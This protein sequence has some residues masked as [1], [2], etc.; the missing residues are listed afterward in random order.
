MVDIIKKPEGETKSRS[1]EELISQG[2]QLIETGYKVQYYTD[3]R[4][5]LRKMRREKLKQKEK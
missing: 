5:A 1:T 2:E 4:A 3:L